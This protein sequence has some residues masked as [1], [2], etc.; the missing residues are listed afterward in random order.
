[1]ISLAKRSDRSICV[2]IGSSL[3]V[4][5]ASGRNPDEPGSPGRHAAWRLAHG[6]SGQP[7]G[8]EATRWL[9]A[10]PLPRIT[11]SVILS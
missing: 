1:M 9:P 10:Q 2:D 4:C 3:P 5:D 11:W 7:S 8:R 6:V